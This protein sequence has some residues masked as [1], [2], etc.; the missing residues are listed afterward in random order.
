MRWRLLLS[1]AVVLLGAC[2]RSAQPARPAASPVQTAP[3]P[4]EA[5]SFEDAQRLAREGRMPLLVEFHAPWCYSCYYMATHVMT[6]PQWDA[7]RQR[8]LTV[9]VDADAPQGAALTARYGIRALPSYLV[10]DAEGDELGRILGEQ[11]RDD[12]YAA[13]DGLLARGSDLDALARAADGTGAAAVD[14][15]RQLL[16]SYHA[17]YDAAGALAWFDARDQVVREALATDA[18]VADW[19]ARLRF[20]CAAGG[21]DMQTCLDAGEAAL[22]GELGCARAYE[23]GRFL[24]CSGEA[25]PPRQRLR[26]QREPMQ[27]LVERGVFGQTRCADERSVVLTMARLDAA[28]GD[29]EAQ[30]A[31]L[32]RAIAAVE[33]RLDG[34]LGRDRN[35]A[36][37]LRVYVEQLAE[38]SGHYTALDALMPALIE[39]WPQ[40]YVYAFR[41]GRSL[42]SRGQAAEALPYLEQ[43][44]Q[45]A[46]GINRLQVAEQRVRAL[47]ALERGD[48]ARR[49]VGEALKA[50]GPWF[51]EQAA[52]LKQLL[53]T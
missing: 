39:A 53:K 16:Q 33:R 41:H 9:E 2:E 35:L 48:E 4:V 52:A 1:C 5:V 36:D 40:D 29:I 6:G 24:G 13:L 25:P 21:G 23:L 18:G 50:N 12:F 28:L 10:L 30:R 27:A 47:L 43:A 8:A 3:A 14:A 15:A 44:A 38:L 45:H 7:V 11:T 49:V 31:L 32:Q 46:Y 51:P 19:L 37:N 34:E 17:R 20:M 26:A 42:L 22:D